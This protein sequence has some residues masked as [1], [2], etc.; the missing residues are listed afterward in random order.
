MEGESCHVPVGNNCGTGVAVFVLTQVFGRG[1]AILGLVNV[2]VLPWFQQG[3]QGGGLRCLAGLGG[4]QGAEVGGGGL[5]V[6]GW[7]QCVRL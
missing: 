5:Q 2:L 3:A 4:G 6:W 7:L 1:I